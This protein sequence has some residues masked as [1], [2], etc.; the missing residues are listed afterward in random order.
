MQHVVEGLRQIYE[1]TQRVG[2]YRADQPHGDIGPLGEQPGARELLAALHE[3][4]PQAKRG[5]PSMVYLAATNVFFTPEGAIVSA[6]LIDGT[7]LLGLLVVERPASAPDFGIED[8]DWLTNI[9][10]QC[11]AVVARLRRRHM[12]RDLDL[13]RSIQR[14]FLQLPTHLNGLRIDAQYKPASNVGGDFYD[15]VP[16]EDGQVLTVI[17]D[18]SGRGM[19]AALY[20]ARINMEFRRLAKESPPPRALL[21]EMNRTV[22]ED[23]T[24]DM[25][26]TAACLKLDPAAH[27]LVVANAGHVLPVVRRASGS[28]MT[29]GG[30]S[31]LPL[32]MMPNETYV[33]QTFDLDP[34]DI[35][36]LMT[37]GVVEALEGDLLDMRALIDI[38]SG[39]PHDAAKINER[40]LRAVEKEKGWPFGD[41]IALLTL[42]V[43]GDQSRPSASRR[44]S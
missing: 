34:G 14:R 25:F 4:L 10:A 38:V 24:D 19:S 15:I 6:P 11:C 21:A 33:D 43:V 37:D 28:V 23:S 3:A 36:L 20:M 22:F 9:A 26:I 39:A 13:A 42:E 2:F 31:G 7:T 18:V 35:V 1:P 16:T 30:A 8:L 44:A 29:L 40:I 17:G 5:R 27:R 12:S 41:D 32:G